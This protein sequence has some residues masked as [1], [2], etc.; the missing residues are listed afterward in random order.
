MY[1]HRYLGGSVSGEGRGSA[2]EEVQERKR[3][4][5]KYY[6]VSR[7]QSCHY[8]QTLES[9]SQYET[10]TDKYI[11]ACTDFA[12]QLPLPCRCPWTK[13]VAFPSPDPSL[14]AAIFPSSV[15]V[16]VGSVNTALICN[17]ESDAMPLSPSSISQ[18][19]EDCIHNMHT[20]VGHCFAPLYR[21]LPQ[22]A[23]VTGGVPGMGALVI[24]IVGYSDLKY[25]SERWMMTLPQQQQQQQH[26]HHTDYNTLK[27]KFDHGI[28]LE[29]APDVTNR[30]LGGGK[31][32]VAM[33]PRHDRQLGSWTFSLSKK[34]GKE[35]LQHAVRLCGACVVGPF[36]P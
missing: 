25:A 30:G 28:M 36:M 12:C 3:A 18:R 8:F 14:W 13:T 19:K 16:T 15:G 17:D 22:F 11:F 24:C 34:S 5:T 20:A 21:P 32:S 7:D 26:H 6:I 4:K 33:S 35:Q 9:G 27:R 1:A 29:S 2:E 23:C 10:V 31:E